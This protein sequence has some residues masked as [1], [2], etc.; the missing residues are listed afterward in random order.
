MGNCNEYL[1]CSRGD[2]I[3]YDR[4]RNDFYLFDFR[5]KL[6]EEFNPQT[7]EGKDYLWMPKTY[8]PIARVDFAMSETDTGDSLRVSKSSPS[9][10]LD[11]TLYS[12]SGNFPIRRGIIGDFANF[13]TL[14]EQTS[15]TFNDPVLDNA[16]SYW[17][18]I[19]NRSLKMNSL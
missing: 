6:L 17:Y 12:G 1:F 3:A 4:I 14:S 16:T 11:W 15:K 13:I 18:D 19:K 9:V 5:G 2:R 10:H 8:E 7:G